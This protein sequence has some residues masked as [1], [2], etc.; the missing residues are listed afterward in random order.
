MGPV[1]DKNYRG[2]PRSR[3]ALHRRRGRHPAAGA[4]AA[5]RVVL[6]EGAGRCEVGADRVRRWSC[7]R[8]RSPFLSFGAP[9]VGRCTA[10]TRSRC[11]RRPDGG[12]AEPRRRL[13]RVAAAG[14]PAAEATTVARRTGHVWASSY[15]H[16]GC[17]CRHPGRAAGVPVAAQ[18]AAVVDVGD[19]HGV[20]RYGGGAAMPARAPSPRAQRQRPRRPAEPGARRP[21]ELVARKERF[22]MPGVGRSTASRSTTR[23]PGPE[24]G[25]ARASWSR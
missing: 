23:S 21:V 1:L 25:S 13:Q 19:G 3:P 18:P 7:C 4:A 12:P 9:G 22:D 17:R 8:S 14:E 16:R 10:S 24:I 5:D 11:S 15:G 2:Q 20:C 6:R